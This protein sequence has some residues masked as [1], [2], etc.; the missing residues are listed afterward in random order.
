MVPTLEN[1]HFEEDWDRLV[2]LLNEVFL[3]SSPT[4]FGRLGTTEID[5]Q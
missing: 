1:I 4:T 3:S 2:I 5:D